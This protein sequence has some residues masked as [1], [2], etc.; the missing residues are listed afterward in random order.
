MKL[1]NSVWIN[2]DLDVKSEYID[3][4]SK[5]YNPEVYQTNFD[6]SGK[7]NICK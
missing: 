5:Y 6:S 7:K 4:L 2:K 3:T 1:A